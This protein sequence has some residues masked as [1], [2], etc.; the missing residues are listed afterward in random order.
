MW[1]FFGFLHSQNLFCYKLSFG[2][3]NTQ[4]IHNPVHEKINSDYKQQGTEA[5]NTLECTYN[6][7]I[8]TVINTFTAMLIN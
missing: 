8:F 4:T 3:A 5:F 1:D 6:F 7:N 2:Y